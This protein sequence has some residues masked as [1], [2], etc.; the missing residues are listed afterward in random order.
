[1][2]LASWLVMVVVDEVGLATPAEPTNHSGNGIS[3]VV[4]EHQN[5]SGTKMAEE[6]HHL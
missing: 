5:V 1:M 3:Q 4:T 2:A 6:Q